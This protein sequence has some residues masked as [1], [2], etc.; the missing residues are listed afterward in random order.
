M[1]RPEIPDDV[2]IV[3]VWADN[4]ED[5]MQQIRAI[6]E[7][8]PYVAMVSLPYTFVLT[9]QDTEFPGVVAHPFGAF[10]KS[11]YNYQTLRVNVD[12][13]KLIQLGMCV[14][15]K[16]GN[17]PP[18]GPCAWQF[19]FKFDLAYVSIPIPFAIISTFTTVSLFLPKNSKNPLFSGLPLF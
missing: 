9:P 15:D 19:H 3:D 17:A 5:A 13:L 7:D 1:K 8:F 18:T 14:C 2:D 10:N 12:M 4:L 6:V 16:Q 11:E